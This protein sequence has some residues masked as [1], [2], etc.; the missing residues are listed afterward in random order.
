[1]RTDNTK[2]EYAKEAVL[3]D[4]LAFC[5]QLCHFLRGTTNGCV[6]GGS[7]GTP[8]HQRFS[9]FTGY[10]MQYM[11]TLYGINELVF[12]TAAPTTT[13]YY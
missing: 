5:V 2:D 11:C 8:W 13:S 9:K 10:L 3:I 4:S 6:G 1:M 12:S 7:L